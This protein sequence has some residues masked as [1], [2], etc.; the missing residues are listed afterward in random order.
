[1][2]YPQKSYIFLLF[3]PY[4]FCFQWDL[5]CDRKILKAMT[6]SVYMAGLLVGSVVFSILSDHFGRK[7]GIFLSIFVM[8]SILYIIGLYTAVVG[9]T[10]NKMS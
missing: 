7:I 4:I 6:Q 9:K 2:N 10:D 3:L 8:V 1:M 5:V